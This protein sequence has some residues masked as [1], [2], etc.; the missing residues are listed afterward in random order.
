MAVVF[1]KFTA[2]CQYEYRDDAHI[3]TGEHRLAEYDALVG[4]RRKGRLG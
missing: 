1:C 4:S 2:G 3:V